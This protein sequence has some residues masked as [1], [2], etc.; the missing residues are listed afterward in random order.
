M[1]TKNFTIKKVQGEFSMRTLDPRGFTP[2]N[3]L[4]GRIEHDDLVINGVDYRPGHIDVLYGRKWW[5]NESE[6]YIWPNES[7]WNER[8][9]TDSAEKI[10]EAGIYPEIEEFFTAPTI[11]EINAGVLEDAYRA[12]TRYG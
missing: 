6:F 5:K 7:R 9:F 3:L 2:G 11:E 1:T 12:G 8:D 10:L 4:V